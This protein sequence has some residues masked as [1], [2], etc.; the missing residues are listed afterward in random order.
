MFIH[1]PIDNHID[2]HAVV[3]FLLANKNIA[4]MSIIELSLLT[5]IWKSFSTYLDS[6]F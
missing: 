3:L 6:V 5:H 4:A 1:F 2:C